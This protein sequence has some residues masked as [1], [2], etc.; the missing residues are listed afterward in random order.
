MRK[1][2]LL[3]AL[4]RFEDDE[5]VMIG[6]LAS[7]YVPTVTRI[8]G[9]TAQYTAHYCVREPGHEGRCYCSCKDVDFDPG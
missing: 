2:Q 8:C 6:E 7:S 3:K 4:E 9:K 5:H 1:G